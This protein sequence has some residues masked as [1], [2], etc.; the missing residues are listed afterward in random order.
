MTAQ[1]LLCGFLRKILHLGE[2]FGAPLNAVE[3]QCGRF[4]RP[5]P[6]SRL[7]PA[8]MYS[9][10]NSRPPLLSSSTHQPAHHPETPDP[11]R[12]YTRPVLRFCYGTPLHDAE[13][14]IGHFR[15][16]VGLVGFVR[17]WLADSED[18]KSSACLPAWPLFHSSACLS[19]QESPKVK[20]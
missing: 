18:F 2:R 15:N 5:P 12:V 7:S 19:S 6:P 13:T 11:K 1:T 8:R 16:M 20:L 3:I 10:A 17:L 14:G 9:S 4:V